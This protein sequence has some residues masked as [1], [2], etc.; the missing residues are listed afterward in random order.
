ML[1]AESG[2]LLFGNAANDRLFYEAIFRPLPDDFGGCELGL[3]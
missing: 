3:R 1:K 2:F